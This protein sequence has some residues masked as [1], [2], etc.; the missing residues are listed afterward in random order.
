[1]KL[2]KE[3]KLISKKN[4]KKAAKYFNLQKGQC[5]HHKDPSLMRNDTERYI[6]WNIED[7]VPMDKIEHL[8]LHSKRELNG[9]YG[10]K[11]TEET[12]IK[13]SKR[14]REMRV[15]GE[16]VITDEMR[17]AYK[18]ASAKSSKFK[19]H[20]HTEEEKKRIAESVRRTKMLKKIGEVI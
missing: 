11:H 2:T 19:G 9:F 18:K 5:L 3:Q 1:M 20:H 6:Q 13:I 15:T 17:E 7:L 10:K 8:A 16:Y 4:H 14:L 12:K